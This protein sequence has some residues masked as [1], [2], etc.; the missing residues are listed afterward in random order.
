MQWEVEQKFR[1]SDVPA[2]E[3]RL[4]ELG[5]KFKAS[6]GQTD[7]YFNHPARD[8]AQTDEAL[9]LRQV[10]HR[11]FVTYKGPKIDSAT[12][13]RQELELPLPD[14]LQ[15]PAQFGL[16]FEALGY[17]PA[18]TVEKN[19]RPGKLAWEGHDVEIAL[20]DVKNLGSFLE[21]EIASDD[22]G[23]D[24]AKS[25]LRTLAQR[26]GLGQSERR[27]YLELLLEK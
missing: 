15:V 13:T 4:A 19:R 11:N 2:T 5:V 18:G 3:A 10:G 20:D 24:A 27:S 12:K 1:V 22:Q 26:L 8:F 14:G 17:R 23:L 6:I 25:A 21:L 16:L 7:R 9:R